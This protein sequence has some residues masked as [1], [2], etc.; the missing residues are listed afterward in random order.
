MTPQA[1]V[2]F[3]QTTSRAFLDQL[4]RNKLIK[5]G[6]QSILSSRDI[7]EIEKYLIDNKL[8]EKDKISEEIAAFFGLAFVHI[9]DRDVP[10]AAISLI[11]LEIAN[12]YQIVAYDLKGLDL[13][14][15]IGQ[16]ATLQ[17]G[18][19]KTIAAIRQQKGFNLHLAVAPESEVLGL[20]NKMAKISSS[21]TQ[22]N[23]AAIPAPDTSVPN[24]PA[25][26]NEKDLGDS[27]ESVA[28]ETTAVKSMNKK[29]LIEEVDPRNKSVDLKEIKIPVETLNKL[30]Y[31]V[32][33]KYK[34]IVFDSSSPSSNL[35]PPMIKIAAVNPDDQHVKEILAYVEQKNKVLVDIYKTSQE[36]FEATLGLY[37]NNK[38]ENIKQTTNVSQTPPPPSLPIVPPPTTENWQDLS[39]AAPTEGV[40]L[41]PSDIVSMP[42]QE[43]GQV[44]KVV[45]SDNTSLEDQNLDKLLTAK[46]ESPQDLA[47]V[48]KSGVIPQ[49]VAATLFLAIRMRASDVHIEAGKDTVRIRYRIDGILHDVLTVPR[50]LHA[51]LISR[52]KILSKM[53]IDEQRVPQDGRF[54]V[55]ID[56]RQVDLRVSTMP[57]VHGEKIV[58]RL[59]DK[60]QGIKSLEQLGVTGTNFD[61][62]IENIDKPY[63]IILST[64]PT[65]SGK[66]TTLY[67]VLTRISKPGV[68]IVTL[69]DPVEYELPGINQ[70]QVKP[71]IGF[72]FAEGLR[73]VLRQDPNVIM[74]GE[75]RDLETAGMATQAALTG[76]LVLS[77]LHTNDASGALPR[78]ID[79][80]VEPF[81]I[82][83][84][85]NAVIGQRLVRKI[86]EDCREKIELP[87]AVTDFIKK[88][89]SALPSGQLKDINIEQLVFYHGKGCSKCTNGYRGRIGIF[90]VLPMSPAI[91]ELSVKKVPASELKKQA[92]ADGMITMV[93]DGLIKALKGITTVDE[94]LRVTTT[95]FKEV[96]EGD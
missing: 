45:A 58:M 10:P 43:N 23:T 62:L 74:V 34:I 29:D 57:T 61:I 27:A 37:D 20:I 49:I 5:D 71:Q 25:Q 1:A 77:T 75:I 93:Q 82:T 42:S 44:P 65:G 79:M 72:T 50:F 54:D 78:L 4:V 41:K 31:E 59:L 67:A 9:D 89:L 11:P 6:F 66:S 95:S 13:F 3:T 90:E 46:I 84:S 12:K 33:E 2:G 87:M 35:E 92:I 52:I 38:P 8:V 32:A 64:G 63:G 88:Q 73:S 36:S 56:S 68:N 69:E 51:P 81:L 30:P 53:K 94:V 80:G 91:E 47:T 22:N 76:H 7:T 86:C 18:A 15:A 40:V 70:A 28:H 19:P 14:L 85:I 83:S 39:V 96:P 55:V 21:L 60:S 24:P 17:Q 16:P 48:F 26:T